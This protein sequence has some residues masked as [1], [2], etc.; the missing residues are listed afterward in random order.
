MPKNKHHKTKIAEDMRGGAAAN[1]V[2]DEGGAAQDDEIL[3]PFK[4]PI[5]L[6]IMKDPV[7]ACDGH[8]YERRAIEAWF[9]RCRN[10]RRTNPG[11]NEEVDA[12][13]LSPMTNKA[14]DND[15]LIANHTLR[16]A[17][18]AF[19]AKI[20]EQDSLSGGSKTA[21]QQEDRSNAIPKNKHCKTTS[22]DTHED[23]SSSSYTTSYRALKD[24]T[25]NASSG[26]ISSSITSPRFFFNDTSIPRPYTLELSWAEQLWQFNNERNN[27]DVRF[28]VRNRNLVVRLL[29]FVVNGKERSA[30]AMIRKYPFILAFHGTV[31]APSGLTYDNFTALQILWYEHFD[32]NFVDAIK[33]YMPLE[34]IK[35]QINEFYERDLS[36][37]NFDVNTFIERLDENRKIPLLR[38]E[39]LL[40]RIK[41]ALTLDEQ[42]NHKHDVLPLLI[43]AYRYGFTFP[44]S[45]TYESE[46]QTEYFIKIVGYLQSKS[47]ARVLLEYTNSFFFN[48]RIRSWS[49]E[50]M[51]YQSN[52]M[53]HI[54]VNGHPHAELGDSFFLERGPLGIGPDTAYS[55]P[56]FGRVW[57]VA[58]RADYKGLKCMLEARNAY[59]SALEKKAKITEDASNCCCI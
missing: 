7:I 49:T 16:G 50:F 14:L 59:F 51:N 44:R 29:N 43:E 30:V 26:T 10:K 20:V 17:I 46:I 9:Q 37:L 19:H 31:T 5:T 35:S 33:R 54:L 15:T 13:L 34:L 11:T 48:C 32:I 1:T 2:S 23:L 3:R 25:S 52:C 39:D 38:R 36:H 47:P 24:S 18:D 40:E 27:F 8:T 28:V 45:D 53:E 4:C 22:S 21:F 41:C 42:D 6:E 56:E 57:T 12:P 58:A 55:A